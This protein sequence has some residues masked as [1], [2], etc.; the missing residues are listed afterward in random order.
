VNVLIVNT[1]STL[2]RGDAAIVLG[3]I[4]LL[5]ETFPGVHLTLTSKT[6][7]L[8]RAL[9]DPLGVEVLPP[10]IP[11]LSS[12]RGTVRSLS[13]GARALVAVGDKGRLL[14]AV[15]RSDLVLSCG[16][17]YLYS[18][19]SLLPGTTFWQ[20]VVHAYLATALHKPLLFL[21][22]SF[23]P[24]GSALARR[25]V[26]TL[27]DRPSVA[28][29][30]AREEVSYHVLGQMLGQPGGARIALCPDMAFYLAAGE[31]SLSRGHEA[32]STARPTMVVNLRE[33][34]FPGAQDPRSRRDAYL[35]AMVA[36]AHH[37]VRRHRGQ[38]VVVPQ[39]LGPDPAEDDRGICWEFFQ[40]VH[41]FP[42]AAQ[43]VHYREPETR[44]L[45][46]YLALLSQ[47]TILVGTRLHACILAL[48][49]GVPALSV[50][51]QPKSQG[52]LD[53]LGLGDLNLDI[54]DLA[55]DRLVALLEA[56]LDRHQA[57]RQEI[58]QRVCQA[59][60]RIE[61]QVGGQMRS[62]AGRG[63]TR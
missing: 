44:S 4:R 56:T 62:A 19:R 16:G 13:Q 54:Q 37:F 46:G 2:N 5:Q 3:Q 21:P 14:Q 48:L 53:L 10:L 59:S 28:G 7:A 51:Y 63:G 40:R 9:Y 17:G 1:C 15:L 27:L 52:T 35:Q 26:R 60:H 42:A 8:D 20:N 12:Y 50:G 33:W 45:T 41:H 43:A 29:I 36:V 39:A 24:F 6:P 30:F 49:C 11:A 55:A 61:S 38:V 31:G 47:A 57:L 18:Y 23:G 58:R 34:A 25:G 22:Q 32:A